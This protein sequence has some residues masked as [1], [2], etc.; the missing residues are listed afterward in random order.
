MEEKLN[1]TLWNEYER[2]EKSTLNW[3]GDVNN[4]FF[5]EL[6][7]NR[8]DVLKEINK[9]H[10]SNADES[11]ELKKIEAEKEIKQYEQMQEN[12]RNMFKGICTLILGGS[13]LIISVISLKK[14]FEF[15][16]TATFT[17]TLGRSV[18]N[19]ASKVNPNKFFK[20]F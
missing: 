19:E 9:N 20:W 6:Q 3:E 13:S 7:K 14:T 8:I 2:L 10:L 1:E 18:V 16:K 11:I 4:P 12:K 5:T 17:S 15:D